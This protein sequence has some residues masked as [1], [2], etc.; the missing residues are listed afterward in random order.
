MLCVWPAPVTDISQASGPA[1]LLP[2]Q[3]SAAQSVQDLCTVV[4]HTT[5]LIMAFHGPSYGL[6]RECAMKVSITFAFL[7]CHQLSKT[8]SLKSDSQLNNNC[9]DC[10]VY[11]INPVWF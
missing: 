10:P 9:L 6:S 8:L 11:T 2:V 7:I 5:G 3:A 4:T 1:N